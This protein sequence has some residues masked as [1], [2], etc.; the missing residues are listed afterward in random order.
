MP[1]DSSQLG[2]AAHYAQS[3]ASPPDSKRI[4]P[5]TCT[6]L[7]L[8]KDLIREYRKIDDSVTMRLNRTAAQ[9]RERDGRGGNQLDDAACA[10]FW[11]QL[12]ANWKGR[13]E[14][15]HYCAEV[16]DR[17]AKEKRDSLL[18]ADIAL[19]GSVDERTRR[20]LQ[21]EAYA[22]EVKRNQIHNELGVEQIVRQRSFDAFRA[23]CKFW[24]PPN[25]PANSEQ[26]QWWDGEN[27]RRK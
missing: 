8:F 19:D 12:V 17:A 10:F 22:E 1:Q 16:V 27:T 3:L 14:V 21:A 25:T 9:F 15:I 24:H 23:R 2:S 4:S 6:Q 20:K 26:I 18:G 13:T 5:D 11:A 7:S